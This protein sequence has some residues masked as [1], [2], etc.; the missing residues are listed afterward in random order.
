LINSG[1]AL[2]PDLLEGVH[3]LAL[4]SG[5]GGPAMYEVPSRAGKELMA[6]HPGGQFPEEVLASSLRHAEM[7]LE[8]GVRLRVVHQASAL[9]HPSSIGYLQAIE[10]RGGL[11]RIR[12]NLPFR[13]LIVDRNAA[14]CAAP[15]E[16]SDLGTFLVRGAR[17]MTLLDRVFETTWV[18]SVPLQSM[19][20]GRHSESEP[21]S[22]SVVESAVDK[23]EDLALAHRF[24]TLTAQQKAILRCLAEGATDQMIAR[25]LGVTGRTVTRRIAEV[26]ETLQVESRF[27]AGVAAHRL[28]LV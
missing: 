23:P 4:E 9:A 8:A 14:V 7:S 25:R 26:Y 21:G 13:M 22:V 17:I 19:L 20:S 16:G 6:L 3:T 2:D 5:D 12:Q 27:Q 15:N 1:D 18:D 11:V 10:D 24:A 28:G